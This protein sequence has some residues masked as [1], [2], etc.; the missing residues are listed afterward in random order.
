MLGGISTAS[1]QNG[2]GSS[3]SSM[4]SPSS[5]SLPLIVQSPNVHLDAQGEHLVSTYEYQTTKVDTTDP[6]QWKAMVEKDTYIFKT[7]IQVPR[8]G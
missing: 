3:S 4:D 7:K 6:H 1:L 2:H 5:T 8:V